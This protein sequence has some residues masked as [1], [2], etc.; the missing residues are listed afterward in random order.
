MISF[1]HNKHQIVLRSSVDDPW[2]MAVIWRSVEPCVGEMNILPLERESV[3]EI[4]DLVGGL[5]N[6]L[7]A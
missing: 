2:P 4:A 1:F 5:M 3:S 7:E 6:R